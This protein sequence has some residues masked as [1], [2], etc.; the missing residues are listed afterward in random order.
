MFPGTGLSCP[1]G[2]EEPGLLRP[3]KEGG[4]VR[5][6]EDGT[7]AVRPHEGRVLLEGAAVDD[8]AVR[9]EDGQVAARGGEVQDLLPKLQLPQDLPGRRPR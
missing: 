4:A 9:V 7:D 5:A 1:S 3:Q 6:L 2:H 8:A